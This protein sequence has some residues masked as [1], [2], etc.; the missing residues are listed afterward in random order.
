MGLRGELPR[1]T[2]TRSHVPHP[3]DDIAAVVADEQG[4]VPV[5]QHADRAAPDLL[6]AGVGAESGHEVL[7]GAGGA[8]LLEGEEY[9][10][11]AD[12]AAPVPRAVVGGEGAAAPPFGKG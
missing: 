8:P 9:D 6:G 10:P 12:P 11:V 2:W 7:V 1:A 5:H 3:P 4:A